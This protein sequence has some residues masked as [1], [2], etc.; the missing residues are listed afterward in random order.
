MRSIR[1]NC[2]QG[3]APSEPASL[4]RERVIASTHRSLAGLD[5]KETRVEDEYA[6]RLRIAC[7][8]HP[9]VVDAVHVA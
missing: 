7:P 1:L 2:K 3:A 9:G 8:A 5:V 4:Q 6:Y